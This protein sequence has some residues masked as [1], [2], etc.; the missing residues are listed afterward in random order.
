MGCHGRVEGTHGSCLLLLRQGVCSQSG[1]FVLEG[2]KWARCA[3]CARCAQSAQS[4]RR[5]ALPVLA[6][7]DQLTSPRI[8]HTRS[9]YAR[10][11]R[12]SCRCSRGL[13]V[14][15]VLMC[16]CLIESLV[17]SLLLTLC[18]GWKW[19]CQDGLPVDVVERGGERYAPSLLLA[20]TF[21]LS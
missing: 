18:A 7:C 13:H 20:V 16:W 6:G 15:L 2:A 21:A 14:C 11:P 1:T 8:Y 12:L 9:W 5:R 4:A 3:R 17:C 19:P 10:L